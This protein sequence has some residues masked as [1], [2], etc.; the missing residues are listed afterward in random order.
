MKRKHI[1]FRI[2]IVIIWLTTCSISVQPQ[3]EWSELPSSHTA[4]EAGIGSPSPNF[5][6]L[7]DLEN[8]SLEL[9]PVFK[10]GGGFDPNDDDSPTIGGVNVPIGDGLETLPI[11]LALYFIFQRFKKVKL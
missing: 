10:S 2:F 8:N 5:E 11:L 7:E 6:N 9:Y 3:P 1:S 4:R